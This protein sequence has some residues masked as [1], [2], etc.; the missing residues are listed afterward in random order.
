M[1]LSENR[2]LFCSGRILVTYS[3]GHYCHMLHELMESSPNN[4]L[5]SPK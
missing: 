2:Q 4:E 5:Y 3:V 1:E